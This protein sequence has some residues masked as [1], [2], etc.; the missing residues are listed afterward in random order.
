MTGL[1]QPS[2]AAEVE[3][4]DHQIIESTPKEKLVSRPLQAIFCLGFLLI[5][6]GTKTE[7]ETTVQEA[8]ELSEEQEEAIVESISTDLDSAKVALG[9]ATQE[10]LAEIDSLLENF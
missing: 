9:K 1:S 8:T 5:S 2:E 4:S 10:N 6:C 3:S 7:Q